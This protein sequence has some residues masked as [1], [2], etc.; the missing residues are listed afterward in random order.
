MVRED[1]WTLFGFADADERTVFEQVQTVT[2]IGPR[3]AL[4]L[5]GTLSP[6]ELRR[7]VAA[8][9]AALTVPGIGRKG[10]QRLILELTDRLGSGVRRRHRRRARPAAAAGG[11]QQ[12][13]AA[14]LASLGWSAREADAAVAA[15]DPALAAEATRGG[16]GSRHR[17]PAQGRP[18]W[19]G[20]LVTLN[21]ES[22][23]DDA[24]VEGALRPGGARRVHRSGAGQVPAGA[25]ARGGPP[26]R[27]AADHVLLSG[28]PGLG[29]TTLASI[30]ATELGA[31]L[32]MTAG[33][34]LQ[35]A[36]DVAA[37]LSSLQPG[38]VL[39]ID[40]VH[41]TARAAEE[42]LYLA[43]EDF[44][45][46]VVVGKGPGATAIPLEIER[47]PWW[48]H[49][50]GRAAAQPAARPVRLHRAPRLLR[51]ADLEIIIARSARL[52]RVPWTPR[53]SPRSPAG[54]GA[55]RASPTGC[56][57]GSATGRRS[58]ATG[59]ST[60]RARTC[61]AGAVR[62]RRAGPG[63]AWTRPSSTRW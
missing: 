15:I 13:V 34:A 50:P 7:A 45:V 6:D 28:P 48:G 43:M 29:K 60:W 35:H 30:I 18:A 1:G 33:P 49:H 53:A 24:V 55:R 8:D 37:V 54:A 56:C 63:P 17:G 61:R 44:R 12:A 59:W 14:G 40:E 3:I 20:P 19:T 46:D 57:A 41:R 5:L 42:M 62:G 36:G 4:A 32:R 47:S 51:R 26:P 27:R 58:M 11:W 25:G 22:D 23:S 2:G 16:R 52:L 10:A 21:A 31:P 9:E 39:F 38:E